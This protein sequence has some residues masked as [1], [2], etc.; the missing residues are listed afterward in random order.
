MSSDPT[1]VSNLRGRWK[2]ANITGVSDGDVVS[3]WTDISGSGLHAVQATGGLQPIFRSS[4][5]FLPNG[6]PCVEFVQASSQYVRATFTNTGNVTRFAVYQ[7]KN[8]ASQMAIY[9]YNAGYELWVTTT[10]INQK[11][12]VPNV[13]GVALV[14]AHFTLSGGIWYAGTLSANGTNSHTTYLNGAVDGVGTTA[15]TTTSAALDFG[16][17]GW[18][19]TGKY[20]DGYI[21]EILDYSRI[22]NGAER[23]VVHSYIQEEYGITVS[24]YTPTA[25]TAI[26]T[27]FR[28]TQAGQL[29]R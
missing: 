29:W 16:G 21:A 2:A 26:P 1:T 24:D 17:R 15:A 6:R 14:G 12:D 22:L 7:V 8:V 23:A 4:G 10:S 3:S 5:A 11:L 9:T 27:F 28:P 18:S 25:G 20:L 13:A 19:G